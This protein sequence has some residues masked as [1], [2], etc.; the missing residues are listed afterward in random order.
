MTG[1][2]RL[3]ALTVSV[4]VL[5]VASVS[6]PTAGAVGAA[7]P[8]TARHTYVFGAQATSAQEWVVPAG[9]TAVT[10][11]ALGSIGRD[12]FCDRIAGN[13]GEVV[14]TLPVT[15]G[16]T[17]QVN[18]A[19]SAGGQHVSGNA[20]DVR[21][22]AF[23][24]SD[25]MIVAGGGGSDA[26][27]AGM[28]AGGNCTAVKGGPGAGGDGGAPSGTTGNGEVGCTFPAGGG[29]GGGTQDAG[30]VGG[31]I[32]GAGGPGSPGTFGFGGAS[33]GS[34]TDKAPCSFG[35]AGGDGWYGGGGGGTADSTD[36]DTKGGCTDSAG[37]PIA[38]TLGGGGGGGSSYVEPAGTDITFTTGVNGNPTG[39]VTI[40]P[41]STTTTTPTVTSVSPSAGPVA[42]GQGVTIVGTHLTGAT[43]VTFGSAAATHVV[44]VSSTKLTARTPAH[45]AA[46][47][48]VRVTT[49]DGTSPAVK[50][51][52]YA[53]RARPAVTSVSPRSGPTA[54]GRTVTVVGK[55]LTAASRVTFAGKRATHLVVVSAT[56]LTVRTPA[57]AAALV[58]VR[59]TTPG[60]RS[61]AVKADHYRYR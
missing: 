38:R 27:F 16:E 30:G 41:T 22:G 48:D 5:L 21:R 15:P 28:D 60:G 54:G 61:A 8:P 4:T 25:R 45:A 1:L 49:P 29:G 56:K 44:V 11:D 46:V 53:F 9:V 52:R 40:T 32:C 19:D 57:H 37:N 51:D 42:G 59:V 14:A 12:T 31:T 13:G 50:A 43:S 36:P 18:V 34:G 35:G 2:F 3:L 55:N 17:L 10:V 39:T 23:A 33:G 24:L 26:D 20:S 6:G 47:V 7:A 58:D